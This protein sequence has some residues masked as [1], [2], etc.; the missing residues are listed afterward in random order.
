MTYATLGDAIA[1]AAE[2]HQIQ[3]GKSGAPYIM[4]PIRVMMQMNTDDERVVAILHDV[5]EDTEVTLDQ[6]LQDGYPEHIVLAVQHLTKFTNATYHGY[7]HYISTQPG[8]AGRIARKVK[9]AVL[10]PH[11]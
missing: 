6:L 4:H 2:A 1:L 8:E 11:D 3:K 9:L 5:I 10:T 7:I